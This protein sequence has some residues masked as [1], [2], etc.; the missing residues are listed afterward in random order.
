[1]FAPDDWMLDQHIEDQINSFA[2]D[3]KDAS[4]KAA[5]GKA[6]TEKLKARKQ[7]LKKTYSNRNKV[8]RHYLRSTKRLLLQAQ[9]L[10]QRRKLLQ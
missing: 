9:K 10:L 1:M 6:A 5:A 3:N 4:K 7:G 2:R 8:L